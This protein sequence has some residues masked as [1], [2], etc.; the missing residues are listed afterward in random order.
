LGISEERAKELE[1][2]LAKPQ[3]TEDEQ[4]YIEAY[5]EYLVDGSIDEKLRKRLDIFRKG[6][7][8]SEERAKELEESYKQ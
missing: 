1:A 8:I 6:L 2:S 5:R 4:E 3:L 7:G